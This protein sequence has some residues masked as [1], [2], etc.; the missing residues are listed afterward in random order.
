MTSLGAATLYY[1]AASK[2]LGSYMTLD[3]LADGA[4][5]VA[6][7]AAVCV[8]CDLSAGPDEEKKYLPSVLHDASATSDVAKQ[9]VVLCRAAHS[10]AGHLCDRPPNLALLGDGSPRELVDRFPVRT[11][12]AAHF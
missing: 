8:R 6:K 7:L 5:G 1:Q 10:R 9:E 3:Y 12:A 11:A 4:L 2:P